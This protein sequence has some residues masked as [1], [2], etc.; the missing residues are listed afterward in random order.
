MEEEHLKQS[1]REIYGEKAGGIFGG[2]KV[3]A[4]VFRIFKNEVGRI[5]ESLKSKYIPTPKYLSKTTKN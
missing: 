2:E 3:D 5:N 4:I 1:E